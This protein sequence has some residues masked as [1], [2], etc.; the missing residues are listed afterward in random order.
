MVGTFCYLVITFRIAKAFSIPPQQIQWKKLVSTKPS[1]M[2]NKSPT[3]VGLTTRHFFSQWSK[4]HTAENFLRRIPEEECIPIPFVD[5]INMSFDDRY[6]D[7][8]A[9]V[10]GVQYSIGSPCDHSVA[11]CYFDENDEVIPVE[12]EEDLMDK[13]FLIAARWVHQTYMNLRQVDCL[14][15][16]LLM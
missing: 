1:N 6:A 5:I 4:R 16:A 15:S 14:S 10:G 12:L 7:A 11:L 2:H 3:F 13:V 8:I 9:H